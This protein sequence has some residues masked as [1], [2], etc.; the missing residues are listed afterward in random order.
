MRSVESN[1]I[2]AATR[3]IQRC[4]V[5][6]RE[7]RLN[8]EEA[9]RK[10]E[11]QQERTRVAVL[12]E[13]SF[14]EGLRAKLGTLEVRLTHV[15]WDVDIEKKNHEELN[16]ALMNHR[17][18]QKEIESDLESW[19]HNLDIEKIQLK[20]E[21][22]THSSLCFQN[23]A[24]KELERNYLQEEDELKRKIIENKDRILNVQEENASLTSYIQR[25]KT[26]VVSRKYFINWLDC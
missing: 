8:I 17:K 6:E 11:L 4:V 1:Q 12:G 13:V 9:L 18:E 5:S 20:A 2:E 26:K 25:K 3:E 19:S 22:I 24:R 15:E 7:A 21:E 14:H 16:E 23:K 10:S